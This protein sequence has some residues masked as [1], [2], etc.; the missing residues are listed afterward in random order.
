M[1]R[2]S[3][4]KVNETKFCTE[5]FPATGA[6]RVA[7]GGWSGLYVGLPREGDAWV[8]G[9][10]SLG[11]LVWPIRGMGPGV[12]TSAGLGLGQPGGEMK[13]ETVGPVCKVSSKT[14]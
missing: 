12:R 10:D 4:Q 6:G 13:L 5:H 14:C 3:T 7:L 2:I 8:L 9:K 1:A 11:G